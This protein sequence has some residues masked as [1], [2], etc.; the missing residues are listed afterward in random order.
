MNDTKQKREY[1]K[2]SNMLYPL[3]AVMVSCA[4]EEGRANVM[5]AAWTGTVCSDPV[6]VY[7]SIRKE[8]YSHDIIERTGEFVI[9]LTTK[10]LVRAADYAGVRSGRSEDKFQTLHLTQAPSRFVKA[11]GIAESPVSLECRV[12]QI[13]RLGS[14]DMFVARV[15]S[16]DIDPA[17]LDEK[18]KFDLDRADLAAYSHG[19]YWSLGEMIG[20]FG[21]SVRKP[22]KK[23]VPSAADK[24]AARGP[25]RI[26]RKNELRAD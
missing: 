10:K 13:L 24:G 2:P 1:W 16:T 26:K 20:T 21:F 25:E 4:D 14:H 18:G 19:E 11:P 22:A 17:Y 9:N 6:M 15:L 5:T 23:R 8:R 3:P 12:E 7:V